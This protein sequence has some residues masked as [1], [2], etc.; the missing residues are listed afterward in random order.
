MKKAKFKIS[1]FLNPSGAHV[2]R[3]SGTLNGKTVRKNFQ[4]REEAVTCKQQLE[5]RRLNE[6]YSGQTIWTTLTREQNRDAVAAVSLLKSSDSSK[7]LT[8]AVDY[9]LKHYRESSETKTV[10]EAAAEYVATKQTDYERKVISSRQAGAIRIEMTRFSKLFGGRVVGEIQTEEI[11]GYIKLPVGNTN[12]LPSLKTCNNR[13][14]Y[15]NTFFKYCLTKGY[16]GVNPVLELPIYKVRK[17]RGTAATL[18]TSEA[19]ELMSWLESYLG[20]HN[21]DGSWWGKPGCMVP[22]F[23]L[24]LFAGIRPDW[25]DG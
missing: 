2:Y 17:A 18:S 25:K 21:K 4:T 14:G 11:G 3:V 24:T 9:L 20:E 5:I 1:P 12:H 23:A 7:N 10:E 19:E 8:F 6:D 16:V 13:R 15:M 22:Y